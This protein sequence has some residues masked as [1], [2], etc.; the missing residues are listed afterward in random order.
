M[1]DSRDDQGVRDDEIP[2]RA[3]GAQPDPEQRATG[4]AGLIQRVLALRP[5]RVLLHYNSDN[6]P[7]IASGMTYQAFFALAGALWFSFAVLGF[8]LQGNTALQDQVFGTI[9]R[10][11]PNLIAYG[12]STTGAIKGADL[13]SASGLSLSSALSLLIVLYTAVGFLATLR[14]AIRIMFGLPNEEGNFFLLKARD[15][16]LAVAFGAVVL[17]TAV[18]TVVS[19]AALDFVLGLLGLGNAGPVQQVLTAAVALVVLAGIEAVMLAAAFRILSGI[20]VP[21]RRLWAGAAIGGVAL[22]VLQTLASSLLHLG[23]NNPVIQGFAV[24]IGLLVFFNFA[25]QIILVA[26]AWVA[27]GMLDAGVDAS[28]LS[29]DQREQSEAERLEDARRL[30]ARANRQAL[31]DRVRSSRGLARWRLSRQLQREVRAEAR[32]RQ[33]VP[34]ASEYREAQQRTGDPSPDEHEVERADG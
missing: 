17:L 25:C 26:A 13:L 32:R 20:P 14:T 24:L 5:V 34:T 27:V 28:S 30:V 2:V 15:L 7:L 22:A 4:I 16:G 6:G 3:S 31:E 23:T 10:F 12:T 19:N 18:I 21:R 33:E 11:L 8:S 1:S 9:N 29:P